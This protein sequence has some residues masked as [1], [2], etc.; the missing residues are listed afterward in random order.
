MK[1]YQWPKIFPSLTPEQETISK[2]FMHYWHQVQPT[3]ADYFNHRYPAKHAVTPPGCRTLE[4]G[5]GIGGHIPYEDLTKQDY[6]CVELRENMAMEIKEKFSQVK[7]SVGDCQ[8]RLG[9]PDKFFNRI[10]AI[11][12]LEHLP[13]LPSALTYRLLTDDGTLDIV[14]P[15]DPGFLYGIGRKISAERIF[16]KRYKQDYNWFIQ[17]E[18]INSPNE[19]LSL[20]KSK[21]RIIQSCY[22]PFLIPIKH[23]NLFI[24]LQFRKK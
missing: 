22:Y 5:A 23:L 11:H 9:F 13:N 1:R 24:G 2:D 20:C 8:E 4:I 3:L 10:I 15:C 17:R 16:R 7:T 12:V 18:H 19:I 14:I 6:Y 21:F